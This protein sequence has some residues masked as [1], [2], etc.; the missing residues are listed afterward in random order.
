MRICVNEGLRTCVC[1]YV[2]VCVCVCV[3]VHDCGIGDII[4][5]CGIVGKLGSF[6]TCLE[7][8]FQSL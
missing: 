6:E 8:G 4:R 1:V 7:W 5:E 2:C 3:C